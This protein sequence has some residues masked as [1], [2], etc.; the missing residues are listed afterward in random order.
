[1]PATADILGKAANGIADNL[2]STCILA[3]SC[4]VV[5]VPSMN[6]Q[7]WCK[8]VVQ[9]NVATLKQ[10]GYGVIAPV[11]GLAMSDGE[12]AG[13]CIMPEIDE[14]FEQAT[15]FVRQ[16]TAARS[17]TTTDQIVDQSIRQEGQAA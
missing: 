9:R 3:A 2:L 1:M 7:M 15:E 8:P 16:T 17:L 6:A 4:P 10:D 14:I 5:F 13:G 11:P 12:S